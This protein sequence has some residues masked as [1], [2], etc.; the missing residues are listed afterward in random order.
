MKKPASIELRGEDTRMDKRI[1][2][3]VGEPLLHLIRNAMAHGIESAS[4]RKSQ[5]KTEEAKLHLFARQL[6]DRVVVTIED[7]GCGLD[8]DR[9]REKAQEKGMDVSQLAEDELKRLI[10]VPGFSTAKEISNLAGRGVGMD[11]VVNTI[12]HL[13]GSIEVQSEKGKG[14]RFDLNLPLTV[15]VVRCLLIEVDSEV[16]AIPLNE[17]IETARSELERVHDMSSRGVI[18]WRGE[19]VPVSDLGELMGTQDAKKKDREFHVVMASGPRKRAILIDRVLGHQDIVA[20]QLDDFLGKPD[21]ISGGTILGDGRV[22]FVLDVT[23]IIEQGIY[24]TQTKQ[25]SVS[26]ENSL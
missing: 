14:T 5:G 2:D 3:R 9:I 17:V 12:S 6:S 24:K 7:D 11:V 1:V 10:F 26:M 25:Q 8:V 16:F 22:V 15:T 23:R 4:E 18:Q 13:G 19:I 21:V 20:K